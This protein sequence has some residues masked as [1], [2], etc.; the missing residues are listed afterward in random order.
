MATNGNYMN[1]PTVISLFAGCGGSSLGYKWAG[2]KELLAIDFDENAHET[3]KLNFDC[4]AWLRDVREVT[5][6]EILD[7]CKIKKGEL[8]VLDGSPPCQGFSTAGKRK[9]CDSRNDLFEHFVR[10]IN[11]LQPK[12]FLMENVSG[13]VKGKMKGLFIEIMKQLKSTGYI[14]KCKR[15]NSMWYGVPQS[16][17]RMIY[18]G[19][20]PD[21]GKE[22]SYPEPINNIITVRKAIGD[23]ENTEKNNRKKCTEGLLK[24]AERLKQGEAA[25]KYHPTGSL[26][27][28]QRLHPN[29]PA[30]T[31]IKSAGT[32][33]LHYSDNL[34]FLSVNELKVLCSFPITFKLSDIRS[35][36]IDRLGNAVMPKFMEVVA[37]HIKMEILN[38][39]S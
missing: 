29:R 6:N 37:N 18:I 15:M 34:K 20:R 5:S 30:P 3:F 12:V 17:E 31:I 27:G 21:V 13:Q 32:G 39:E 23:L 25:S 10:L 26:F 4:P 19:T 22:P 36:A 38:Y 33:L 7:F 2:Y 11:E 9:I 24:Y 8:D 28:L 35:L 14:V 1:K 16:R